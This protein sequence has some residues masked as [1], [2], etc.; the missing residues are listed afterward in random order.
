MPRPT[1]GI[2]AALEQ[3]RWGPWDQ[4]AMLVPRTYLDVV[5]EAG[6]LPILLPPQPSSTDSPGEVVDRIDALLLI[7][8]A[9]LHPASYGG[10]AHPEIVRTRPERDRFEIALAREAVE[11]DLPVLGICRGM[12]L[13]NVARGGTLV[14]HLPDELGDERH[15][16][17]PGRFAEHSVR[18]E[19]GSLAA[20]AAGTELLTVKTHHHQGIA[21]LG[22][23]LVATGWAQEDDLIEAIEMPERD[24]VLGV[25]WHPEADPRNR[26]IPALV[27]RAARGS[28]T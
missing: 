4:D 28:R 11:R 8:G 18:L 12:Q 17:T 26:V 19:P 25:L 22:D 14:P 23:D 2:C 1:I 20:R 21:R 3:A 7:G 6:G 13:L 15:E 9:D 10:D 5:G 16:P 27:A 24:F